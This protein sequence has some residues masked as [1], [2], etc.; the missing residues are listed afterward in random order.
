MEGIHRRNVACFDSGF[1]MY[2][3]DLKGKKMSPFLLRFIQIVNASLQ[4][5]AKEYLIT[6]YISC[7]P[8]VVHLM[9]QLKWQKN[10]P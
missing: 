8:F 10:E 2:I 6:S 3:I 9:D 4:Q 1:L 7:L 5:T